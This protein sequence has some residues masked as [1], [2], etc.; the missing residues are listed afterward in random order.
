METNCKSIIFPK[1]IQ[2]ENG[3]IQI[4]TLVWLHELTSEFFAVGDVFPTH[5]TLESAKAK[6]KSLSL[7]DLSV[8]KDLQY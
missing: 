6:E 1:V 2:G 3:I 5:I 7:R 4:H 8:H